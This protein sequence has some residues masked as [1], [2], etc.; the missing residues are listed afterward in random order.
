VV[1]KTR[2]LD[3]AWV[4]AEGNFAAEF[5]AHGALVAVGRFN[6]HE[7][8]EHLGGAFLFGPYAVLSHRGSRLR[9]M[10]LAQLFRIERDPP[11]H[12]LDARACSGIGVFMLCARTEQRWMAVDQGWAS[13]A[14]ASRRATTLAL[15]AAFTAP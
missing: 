9:T 12:E 14:Q 13:A 3:L 5:G 4:F 15:S 1:P 2:K 7:S 10:L 11:F 8:S 6:L